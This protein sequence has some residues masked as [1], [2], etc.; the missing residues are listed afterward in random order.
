MYVYC[1][2]DFYLLRA[3][4]SSAVFSD[5]EVTLGVRQATERMNSFLVKAMQSS[6]DGILEFRTTIM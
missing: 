6:Q 4:D 3:S 1:K 5:G 2:K